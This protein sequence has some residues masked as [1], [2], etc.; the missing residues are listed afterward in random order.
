[1]H[2]MQQELKAGILPDYVEVEMWEDDTED[3]GEIISSINHHWTFG[4]FAEETTKFFRQF[5]YLY[6][7]VW[8]KVDYSGNV[9]FSNNLISLF[10]VFSFV[11]VLETFKYTDCCLLVYLSTGEVQ[12]RVGAA[13]DL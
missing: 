10:I 12:L 9:H 1:M 4:I 7:E 3:D 11:S 5:C 8:S 13:L 2:L 6:Y